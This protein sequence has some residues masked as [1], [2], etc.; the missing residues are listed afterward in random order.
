MIINK[1][2]LL[3]ENTVIHEAIALED[4]NDVEN[5]L[6]EEDSICEDIN[7]MNT[8][9][10]LNN[11]EIDIPE[12]D[13]KTLDETSQVLEEP[14]SE[15]PNV[16]EEIFEKKETVETNCLALTV[17]KNYNISIFKNTV[18]TTFRVSCKVAIFT[19]LLNFLSLLF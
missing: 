1:N 5:K 2:C 18:F 13:D 4:I 12:T 7:K 3:S 14:V 15:E 16:D 9:N 19:V 11:T 17:R 6:I 10:E 8:F